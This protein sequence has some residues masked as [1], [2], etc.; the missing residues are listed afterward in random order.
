MFFAVK[1]TNRSLTDG[2]VKEIIDAV[3]SSETDDGRE[4][5]YPSEREHGRREK[6]LSGGIDVND[7]VLEKIRNL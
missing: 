6:G 7:G 1:V 2:I 3:K 5:Y 4:I